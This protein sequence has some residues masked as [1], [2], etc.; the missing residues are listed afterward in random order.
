MKKYF[1]IAAAALV[2]MCACTKNEVAQLEVNEEISFKVA[3]YLSQ[4]KAGEVAFTGESF[5]VYAYYDS[6]ASNTASEQGQTFMA[7]EKVV[8]A[9]PGWQ[10]EGKTYYWPKSGNIDF[11]AYAPYA[12]SGAWVAYKNSDHTLAGNFTSATGAEDYLYSSMAMNYTKND[13]QY[14]VSDTDQDNVKV[15]DGVP[16]L[17][18]HAL[19]KL[20]VKFAAS[21]LDDKEGEEDTDY[22]RWEI[23]VNTAEFAS[24]VKKGSLSMN[25]SSTEA[26]VQA[27]T[28]PD[29]KIWTPSSEDADKAA[30]NAA[31]AQELT[32]TA[33]TQD[34]KLAE[35]TVLPQALSAINF[36][37][38]YT[39]KAYKNDSTDPYS[40]ETIDEVLPIAGD[41]GIFKAAGNYWEMNKKYTYTVTIA[42]STSIIYFDPAVAPWDE[43]EASYEFEN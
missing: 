29:N 6:G 38:N 3:N 30:L 24:V 43:A 21:Q 2:A 41:D 28:L 4:T 17:F 23:T 26:G 33:T 12:S 37:I 32:T 16:V 34:G 8:P 31:T 40:T 27:W 13:P 10:V 14:K 1:V 39:I 7:N 9:A 11:F 19:A 15:S 18:H 20:T 25:L 42:P 35:W 22:T 5:G 36:H